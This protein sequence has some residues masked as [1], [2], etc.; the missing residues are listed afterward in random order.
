MDQTQKLKIV[1]Q[2]LSAGILN[3]PQWL[4]KLDEPMPAWVVIDML[5]KIMEK[6]DPPYKSYD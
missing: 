6:V 3:D 4:H 5:I 1:K 2:A